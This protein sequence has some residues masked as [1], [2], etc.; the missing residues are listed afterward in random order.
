MGIQAVFF[1][2]G[3]TI[4]TMDATRELRLR[5][6]P[7]L[8]ERLRA[9]GIDLHLGDE[10]LYA[11]VMNG[12]RRY[13]AWTVETTEE[14]SPRRVWGEYILAGLPVDPEIVGAAAQDLMFFLE[15]RYYQ[16]EM[17]PEMPEVLAAIKKMGLK[18]GLIS[19]V[20]SKDQVPVNLAQY[21]IREYFDPIVLSGE[22]G[23]RKPDPAIFHHAARLANVPTGGCVYVG[24]RIAR[25]I[26]GA[27]RAGFKLAIQIRH[28]YKHGEDDTGAEPDAI[29][30]QMTELLDLLKAEMAA[31][32]RLD[33][34]QPIRALLFDAGDIL[35]FRPNRGHHL[36]EF[37]EKQG[38]A[39]KELPAAAKN[40][41]K[42]QAYHGQISRGQYREGILRLYGL[43]D[44][45]LIERGK[46]LMDMDDN[47]IE[48]F[49]GVA[50][51][52]KKLKEQGYMLGII[53]D[54]A[55]PMHVKLAWFE[56]GGFGHVWDSIVSSKEVGVQKPD[57]IIYQ[58]ALEQLGLTVD[59]A[60][61]VGHSPEELDGAR[62]IGM[63]TIAFNYNES[64]SA[65]Y[66]VEQFKDLLKVPLICVNG[67]HGQVNSK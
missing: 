57:P 11:V 9:A 41:L 65:D 47:N 49:K 44:P 42:H 48:F 20:C 24:D 28:D 10:E 40:A 29:I 66:Y 14:L 54:T 7:E 55:M 8:Q 36:R 67:N 46:K 52:L 5:A 26:L 37:L 53:T 19:N 1:D 43:S 58:A 34:R 45:A 50:A 33:R 25:D 2:M 59:Q 38:L 16:R 32:P 21:G 12:W 35:Y 17:R 39:S 22:Y 15:T 56:Q 18:I 3:G 64:A 63:K 60:A 62:A 23:R 4:E 13:H 27:R 31:P 51:T 61:F 6:T 30:G